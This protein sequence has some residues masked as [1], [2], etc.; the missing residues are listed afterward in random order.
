MTDKHS[1]LPAMRIAKYILLVRG[2]KVMLD[3]DLAEIHRVETKALTRAVR[4]NIRRFPA[5]FI[6]QLSAEEFQTL[7]SQLGA[8]SWGGR[9]YRPYVLTEHGAVMLA[10]V[11]NTP[12]AINAS[13]QV[14]RAFVRLREIIAVHKDLARKLENLEKK[15]DSQFRV[16]FDAIRQLMSSPSTKKRPIG[17]NA[18]K[19]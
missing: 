4:R 6:F 7:R 12:T 10:S 16:V 1:I 2:Q 18:T 17:F 9:R 19:G 5:D 14:V 3:R 8:S 11:L 15:Y 13:I